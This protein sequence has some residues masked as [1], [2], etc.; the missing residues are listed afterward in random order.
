MRIK[1]TQ[2]PKKSLT[3]NGM[4]KVRMITEKG[5]LDWVQALRGVAAL[6]VVLCHARDYL[7]GTENFPFA[8]SILLPGA[9]GVDLFFI[10]SGF[11]MV[12]S[13]RNS[14]G[15]VVY[16]KGFLIKRFSRVWPTYTAITILWV[17]S[18]SGW[19][20]FL[21]VDNFLIFLKSIFFIPVKEFAPLY[22]DPVIPIGWTLN[23][24]IYFY[25]VFGLSL[26]FRKLSLVAMMCWI[27]LTVIVMPMTL[28]DF[29]LNPFTYYTFTPNYLNLMA[30]PIILEF[31]AG[32]V[33]GFLYLNKKL[34]IKN[35]IVAMN[36]IMLSAGLVMW[37]NY[38]G[39]GNLHGITNWGGSLALLVL[40]IAIA[41][42]SI[43]LRI[44]VPLAWLGKISFSL[45][46]THYLT[47]YFLDGLMAKVGL[48]S[49]THSWSYIVF[50]TTVCISVAGVSQYLL[51][52]KLSE[53]FR[54]LLQKN[55]A[56]HK[57][58]L[59]SKAA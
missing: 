5:K 4:Y 11:I 26:L 9:M 17:V 53:A 16:A 3:K 6:L 39:A 30:N 49:F 42:K 22:F 43:H 14:D 33:I 46:L 58:S 40:C 21:S 25:A 56:T 31:V 35:K 7:I 10:I 34:F 2:G 52:N 48:S 55:T 59:P 36:L 37:Y 15:S 12:Y 24:E 54:N 18:I 47:R 19:G 32:A 27:G 51:E 28:R 45:Y 8:E 1:L 44:P 29:S 57:I 41:S 13:T 50:S 23:F 38:S 20:Y